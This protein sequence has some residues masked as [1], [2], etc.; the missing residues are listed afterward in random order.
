MARCFACNEPTEH[1]DSYDSLTDRNYC[2]PCYEA[3]NE[4]IYNRDQQELW[5]YH[6]PE[7]IKA[8]FVR[9]GVDDSVSTEDLLI[10][11]NN[12]DENDTNTYE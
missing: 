11:E 9:E 4:V 7:V 3:T 10:E 12:V 1:K 2:S 8:L 6:N 5:Q